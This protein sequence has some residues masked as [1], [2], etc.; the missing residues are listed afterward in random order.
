MWGIFFAFVNVAFTSFY[1]GITKTRVLTISTT[2]LSLVNIILDYCLIFGHWGFPEMG[3]GGAALASTIAEASASI[4]FIFYT[5]NFI[6]IKKYNL[7]GFLKYNKV[8]LKSILNISAPVMAQ[9]FISFSAWFSFFMMIEHMG[10]HALAISNI[11]RSVYILLMIPIWGLSS[12]TN[13]LVSNLIGAGRSYKVIPLIKKVIVI[14]LLC[15]FVVILLML[16]FIRPLLSVY[17]KDTLL[18]TDTIP[19]L[20]VIAVAL[21]LFS[22]SMIIFNGVSGSG[23]TKS[24]FRIEVVTILAYLLSTFIFSRILHSKVQMVWCAEWVYMIVMGTLSVIYLKTK[25]WKSTI[26]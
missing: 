9:Y 19:A 5:Y 8:M 23:N 16:A 6:D 21:I 15:T 22:V 18:I 11:A 17:T 24:S 13:T 20:Y 1:I 4:F 14:S 10:Q 7:F 26:I 3:V 2:L 25:D 12:A